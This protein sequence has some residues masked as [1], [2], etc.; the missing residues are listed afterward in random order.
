MSGISDTQHR[1]FH[2]FTT[3]SPLVSHK[4]YCGFTRRKTQAQNVRSKYRGDKMRKS[5]LIGV[6]VVTVLAILLAAV[7]SGFADSNTKF[8]AFADAKA[9]EPPTDMRLQATPVLDDAEVFWFKALPLAVA[10]ILLSH[11]DKL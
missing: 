5:I 4:M 1:S 11:S 10:N 9:N 2:F 3:L 6:S 8:N 7:A